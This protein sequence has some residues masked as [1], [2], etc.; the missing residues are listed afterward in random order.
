MSIGSEEEESSSSS[1]EPIDF[2]QN[3]PNLSASNSSRRHHHF[4]RPKDLS[5]FDGPS[6]SAS[7]S[8]HTVTSTQKF[9]TG[10]RNQATDTGMFLFRECFRHF[11]LK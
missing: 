9:P 11:S 8:R 1:V 2:K 5:R 10:N 6:S 3:V 7:S 4:H